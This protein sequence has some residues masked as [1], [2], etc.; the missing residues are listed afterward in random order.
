[1]A[2]A[3][4]VLVGLTTKFDPSS[5][6]RELNQFASNVGKRLG[7][8]TQEALGKAAKVFSTKEM[9]KIEGRF[10]AIN[11]RMT[12]A[13][14]KAHKADL[15]LQDETISKYEKA[16]AQAALKVANKTL[17]A[18][19]KRAKK[20]LENV[21]GVIARREKAGKVISGE[22]EE[23]FTGESAAKFGEGIAGAFSDVMSADVGSMAELIRKAGR[24]A[25]ERGAGL[26][27]GAGP[28]MAGGMRGAAGS[29]IGKFGK[30]LGI[31][32]GIAAGLAAISKLIFD[33][34]E[35]MTDINKTLSESG[36]L[37]G[38][39]ASASWNLSTALGHVRDAAFD[40]RFNM[41]WGTMAKE[42]VEILS[43][44]NEAGF[45]L[46]EMTK[47]IRFAE[48][49]MVGYQ[50]ATK[51]ALIYSKLLG[52]S[53][54]EIAQQ[55]AGFMEDLGLSLEG[56]RERF[57]AI[58]EVA[59]QSGYSTKRF[60]GM[61]LQATSGMAM[62]NVRLEQSA[63]LM[64]QLSK[65]LGTKMGTDFFQS[66]T[67]AFSAESYE[68]RFRRMMMTGRKKTAEIMRR[69]AKGAA[70]DFGEKLGEVFARDEGALGAVEDVF[71]K[72]GVDLETPGGI[73]GGT[74][75]EFA[76]DLRKGLKDLDPGKQEQLL[77][78][79]RE[80]MPEDMARQFE[81]LIDVTRASASDT[82]AMLKAMESLDPG[83][84]LAMQ[85]NAM[86]RIFGKPLHKLNYKQLMAF[87]KQ[88]GIS[89]KQL[90]QLRRVSRGIYGSWNRLKKLQKRYQEAKEAAIEGG[91]EEQKAFEEV[92][93]EIASQE[94]ELAKTHQMILKNGEI[95]SAAIQGDKVVTG[96]KLESVEDAIQ[97]G[98]SAL[99]EAS[100]EA[101]TRQEKAALAVARST[102]EMSQY[103]KTGADA[104]LKGIYDVSS[105]I[106]DW[107]AGSRMNEE[108][109]KRHQ[110][111]MQSLRDSRKEYVDQRS[112]VVAELGTL[113]GKMETAS[114]E[115]EQK[116]LTEKMA[117]AQDNLEKIE[118]KIRRTEF[119]VERAR[120][121]KGEWVGTKTIE[122]MRKELAKGYTEGAG[123]TTEQVLRDV[124]LIAT[125]VSR[126][127][128][129]EDLQKKHR[130]R[131]AKE[132]TE[133]FRQTFGAQ[134]DE[135]IERWTQEI[136]DPY[137]KQLS[138]RQKL[139]IE[140]AKERKAAGVSEEKVQEDLAAALDFYTNVAEKQMEAAE[141]EE[142]P[143]KM[144]AVIDELGVLEELY[145]YTAGMEKAQSLEDKR[146][147]ELQEK[148]KKWWKQY[149]VKYIGEAIT[150]EERK[151]SAKALLGMAGIT[152]PRAAGMAA[153]MVE[154]PGVLPP[155]F[156]DY[157]E[158]HP[159]FRGMLQTHAKRG[160]LGA[161]GAPI[162]ALTPEAEKSEL[163]HDFLLRVGRRGIEK[164]RI[165]PGD[166]VMGTKP[167]GAVAG[168]PT[169]GGGSQNVFHM[170]N[171]GPGI[172]RTVINAQKAGV[173][174]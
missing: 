74:M 98:D 79:L 169:G 152:G 155:E 21:K 37:V 130:E 6:M 44:W 76:E 27:A 80:K 112:E 164:M 172:L 52:Q 101:M 68:D 33:I 78:Q 159:E 135:M 72:F 170:Y 55:M 35:K 127:T 97:N 61:V 120:K 13:L 28:G 11:Q 96:Q 39:L 50:K 82:G 128:D 22:V 5:S 84:T 111:L 106:M 131:Q 115:E 125:G 87:E 144:Q 137:E 153:K 63:T 95:V 75:E 10:N 31:L 3:F 26:E 30:L 91:E 108:E 64:L 158:K 102:T 34:D 66:M 148:M 88:T 4:D 70:Y 141:K 12:T 59:M 134:A 123:M 160:S 167:G 56:V 99:Q 119:E 138:S 1:M 65:I 25:K 60:A 48:N 54:S 118:A 163:M 86:N 103:L 57:A 147:K 105:S 100:E 165:D 92:A 49:Y 116:E 107:L 58:T 85:L 121:V 145:G 162:M 173:L 104:L 161:M 40:V 17:A 132:I 142:L 122:D 110:E 89:G 7:S 140:V 42:Q 117:K 15:K 2:G 146:Q 149:G 46:K 150:K 168:A 113:Q 62:Y 32:G 23:A 133:G 124:G 73:F 81:N 109:Q 139:A 16:K 93:K 53:S 154:K 129:V 156:E 41:D 51:T 83:A 20:E 29:V 143:K 24:G 38:D 94:K 19:D 71:E 151:E 157:L 174:G 67:E 14:Q 9:S 114:S 18:E 90:A 36:G 77:A 47:N 43:A 166:V 69:S 45:T 136:R 171:D 126:V 8:S